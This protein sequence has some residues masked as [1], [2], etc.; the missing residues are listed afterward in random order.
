MLINRIR[1]VIAAVLG[2][3]ALMLAAAPMAYAGLVSSVNYDQAVYAYVE[4]SDVYTSQT[5]SGSTFPVSTSI[6]TTTLD[7]CSIT[8]DYNF[9]NSNA[10]TVFDISCSASLNRAGQVAQE[11]PQDV[12]SIAFVLT[13]QASYTASCSSTSSQGTNVFI[14]MIFGTAPFGDSVFDLSSYGSTPLEQSGTISA[15][16]YIFNEG[17]VFGNT[18]PNESATGTGSDAVSLRLTAI[19]EPSSIGLLA[20]L[21]TGL[22][23]RRKR[24]ALSSTPLPAPC[25]LLKPPPISLFIRIRCR[26]M[27]WN[28]SKA[29]PAAWLF[30]GI[31]S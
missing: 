20:I 9:T 6:T 16:S 30:G 27:V 14:N 31:M 10:A 13:Q 7:G 4:D 3:L 22:L 26:A 15:G 28:L 5:L 24:V 17:W 25:G 29:T 23:T 8:A 19:P 1:N 12:D 21:G 18:Q 2:A 11:V